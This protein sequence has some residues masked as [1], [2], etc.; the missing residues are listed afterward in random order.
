MGLPFFD[1]AIGRKRDQ[2]MA[3]D[4]GSRTT[5]AVCVA[6]RGS[7][8]ALRGYAFL[9]APICEKSLPPEL[10]SEHLKAVNQALQS[11]T[12]YVSLTAGVGDVQ[13][14]HV[15]LP[16]MPV[17]DMRQVLKLNSKSYLQQDLPGHT[18]DCHVC[19]QGPLAKPNGKPQDAGGP[20]KHRV[21]IAGARKQV[22]DDYL[23]GCKG[24]GLVAENIVP[25]LISPFNTFE[26][27][28]PDAFAKEAVALV[29][30]GFKNTSICI[31]KEGD[32]VLSRVVGIG[33]DRMTNSLAESLSISYAEAEGIKIG[34]PG[35]VQT[36]L[37][38]M[39]VPLGRE[40][41][42]SID[43]FEHQH[44]RPVTQ[45]LLTGGPSQSEFV[46]HRLQ[47]ELMVDCKLLNP[48][49]FLQLDLPA[50]QTAEIEQAAPQLTVALGAALA[51]L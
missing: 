1:S 31:A 37:E 13:V 7:G 47:Q 41:R 5:K 17:S 39:L 43:F 44:D 49:G 23:Q 12:K 16:R 36:Q 8:F 10:L 34:M 22:V 18:Y 48:A 11:P 42:A 28:M 3:V 33:G 29:D 35:E 9:D 45:V 30:L 51:A 46:T 25:G 20:P 6:R 21:L 14:R 24:A 2:V 32:L 40:L 50:Q 19:N 4:L 38:S 15:D 26:R 27:A